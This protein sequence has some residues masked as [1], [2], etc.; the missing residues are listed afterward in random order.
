MPIYEYACALCHDQLEIIQKFSDSPIQI[1][2]N[3]QE[4]SLNKI[5][6][7]SGFRL[8]GSGW[9]ETDYKTSESKKN[10]ASSDNAPLPNSVSKASTKT[11][12]V[13]NSVSKTENKTSEAA[14]SAR[15][16]PASKSSTA[17]ASPVNKTSN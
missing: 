2:P 8:K 11:P 17:T 16:K 10:L 12:K 14:N 1:C 3:C 9:Y 4:P 13:N 6:S 7:P 5:M 15:E